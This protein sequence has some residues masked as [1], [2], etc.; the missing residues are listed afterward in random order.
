M[1]PEPR[2]GV[3][4]AGLIAGG[5]IA[6]IAIVWLIGLN[7][8]PH[9][10][11]YY[12]QA[13]NDPDGDGGQS[14]WQMPDPVRGTFSY[15]LEPEYREGD[16][17]R[18][19][20]Y[21][22]RAQERVAHATDWIAWLTLAACV[23]SLFALGALIYTLNLQREANRIA[24]RASNDQLRAYLHFESTTIVR[25]PE[26]GGLRAALVIRNFGQTPARQIVTSTQE[27]VGSNIPD[28]EIIDDFGVY[29]IMSDLGPQQSHTYYFFIDDKLV[30]RI[31]SGDDPD[32]R[33]IK[34]VGRVGYRDVFGRYFV[35]N[36]AF[37]TNPGET[38]EP[39]VLHIAAHGNTST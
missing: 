14:V 1:G 8:C 35:T 19:E 17:T 5:G 22:L 25:D 32:A 15:E 7:Y 16:P 12:E 10:P 4:A 11:C 26:R 30:E 34:W 37:K 31:N 27:G 23:L 21:D 29:E 2:D 33:Q 6:I 24:R 18:Y 3:F 38:I 20:Y 9:E 39:R 28:H 36:F 13:A